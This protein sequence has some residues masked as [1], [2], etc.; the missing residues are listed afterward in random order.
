[1]ADEYNT[2]RYPNDVDIYN[3][4]PV[5]TPG[6]GMTSFGWYDSDAAFQADA[7]RVCRFIASRLGYPVMDV[8]LQSGSMFTCFEEAVT[9]YGNQVYAYKVRENYL[10]LEGSSTAVDANNMVVEPTLQRIVE[11]AKNYGTEAD[12]GGNVPLQVDMLDIKAGVQEYD[13]D[14]WARNHGIVGG[15]EIRRIFYE[16][17]PAILRYFDPYAGTG[18]GVQSLMDAFDFGSYSPGINFLLMPVSFDILKVQAIEFN[19]QVRR[20]AYSFRINN[21]KLTLFPI[22]YKDGKLRIEYYKLSDKRKLNANAGVYNT[23]AIKVVNFSASLEPGQTSATVTIEHD[24]NSPD[25][26]AQFYLKGDTNDD[27]TNYMFIPASSE[28]ANNN[29]WKISVIHDVPQGFAVFTYPTLSTTLDGTT[30]TSGSY[31]VNFKVTIPEGEQTYTQKFIHNL[32]TKEVAVQVYEDKDNRSVMLPAQI[33]IVSEYEVDITFSR[34]I[35]GHVLFLATAGESTLDSGVITNVSEVPYQNPTY[36]KINSIGRMW[37]FRYTLALCK[38]VLAYIRGKYTN[39]PIPDSGTTLNQADLL[40]DARTEKEAL[41]KELDDLL[42]TTSRNQQL[43]LKAA[44]TEHLR[45]IMVGVPM[46][47]WVG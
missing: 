12:V 43:E 27:Q 15:I 24:L 36:S 2:K 20:S 25:V 10:S 6:V 8:E 5:F 32:N 11:I 13:L 33:S 28:P 18:T 46:G 17:P 14:L 22:P 21:N 16:A 9:T 34:D 44:E 45:Q 35:E 40:S 26:K 37:I 23:T 47:V 31:G 1:M 30:F 38:E 42:G 39:L 41:L 3:G 7:P 29:E 19:D 4:N